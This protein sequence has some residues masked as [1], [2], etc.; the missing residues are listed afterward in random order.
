MLGRKDAGFLRLKAMI[1]S[2]SADVVQ[3]ALRANADAS[4]LTLAD[5]AHA[6]PFVL[7]ELLRGLDDESQLTVSA[8]ARSPPAPSC[9]GGSAPVCGSYWAGSLR[10]RAME[11]NRQP[12][13]LT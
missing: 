2:Q 12:S 7:M 1:R 11:C 6:N 3:D 13:C 5:K 9:P 10:L 4:L 8:A